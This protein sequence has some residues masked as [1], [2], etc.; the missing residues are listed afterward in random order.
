MLWQ[1]GMPRP[2]RI[3]QDEFPYHATTRTSG[4]KLL[5]KKWTYKIII[6]VLHEAAQRYDVMIEHFKMMGNH[7]HLKLMTP[8]SNLDRV[9][10][11]INNQISKRINKRLGITGHLWGARYHATII[12]S[13]RHAERCV[14]YMYNNGVK[15]GLCERASEDEQLSTFEFYA[16]GRKVGFCV[17]EDSV[18]LMLGENRLERERN[19]V[20]MVDGDRDVTEIEAIQNGLRKMFYGSADFVERMKRKYVTSCR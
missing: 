4:R 12:E 13:D 1:G 7:Y 5:F 3:F 15:A 8:S 17:S 11:Y 19:F 9:M 14:W 2:N 18:Y 16:R 20:L 6:G 10:W